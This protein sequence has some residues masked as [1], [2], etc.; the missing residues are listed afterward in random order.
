MNLAW[1]EFERRWRT[2]Y[3]AELKK[4]PDLPKAARRSQK[5]GAGALPR[6]ARRILLPIFWCSLFLNFAGHNTGFQLP[7]A[8]LA[9]WAA[10]TAFRWGHQWFQQFY[11]SEDLVVLH[12]LPLNDA[13]IFRFQLRRYLGSAGWL[14]W[15]IGL[16]YLALAFIEGPNPPSVSQLLV[17]GILQSGL[18][19]ALAVHL[20]SW[21]HL[22]PLGSLGA[23]LRLSAVTLLLFGAQQSELSGY[24]TQ[25]TEWFLPTGWVNYVLLRAGQDPIIYALLLPVLAL[26]YLARFSFL[27]LRSFYSLAGVEILSPRSAALA[28]D[29]ELTDQNTGRRAGP[30]EI[31]D[32]VLAR[33]FLEGLNWEL[34]GPLERFVARCLTPRQRIITEFLVAGSPGWT[35]GW[36][37]SFWIWLATSIVVLVL[38]QLGGTIT[39]F[40]TY[41]LAT[42]SLPIFGGNWRGMRLSASGGMYLPAFSVYPITFNSI[43]MIFLKVNLVRIMA[44]SPLIVSFATL[45]AFRLDQPPLIGAFNAL[46]LL[47]ILICVQPL[48]ILFPLSNTTNYTST[49]KTALKLLVLV[50]VLL[51]MFGAAFAIFT[52]PGGGMVLASYAILLL[53][54]VLLFAIF[55]RAYRL[56]DFDLLSERPPRGP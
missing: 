11:A 35:Q 41:V 23:L 21:V 12:F 20:A 56:G 52:S 29:E 34:T 17:A 32:G 3:R 27:R 54:S 47:G 45:A 39:F 24:F 55:R 22:I 44:A 30:T 1:P 9:L 53:L 43:A 40:A 6:V 8:A 16:A 33:R 4:N 36:K 42:S 48:F 2:L 51:V 15:E 28:H 10:G 5:G 19:I 13:Q 38:G 26:I 14:F 46:R 25:S 7:A 18:V 50:P 49:G 31:E 37:V